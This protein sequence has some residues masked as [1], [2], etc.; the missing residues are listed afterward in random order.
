M[1][2]AQPRRDQRQDPA[3]DQLL[4]LPAQQRG[5]RAADRDD[6]VGIVA[7]HHPP[8]GVAHQSVVPRGLVVL[9]RVHDGLEA[10]LRGARPGNGLPFGELRQHLLARPLPDGD[11]LGQPGVYEQL[12]PGRQLL[13]HVEGLLQRLIGRP[14]VRRHLDLERQRL[15]HGGRLRGAPLRQ[16]GSGL[17]RRLHRSHHGP[18]HQA[19]GPVGLCEVHV[20]VGML[21]QVEHELSQDRVV[22][23]TC[24]QP[25]GHRHRRESDRHGRRGAELDAVP[26]TVHVPVRQQVLGRRL[27]PAGQAEPDD[28]APMSQAVDPAGVGERRHEIHPTTG[29]GLL[30]VTPGTGQRGVAVVDLHPQPLLE[31]LDEHLDVGVRVQRGVGDHLAE[32]QCSGVRPDHP[33]RRTQCALQQSPGAAG[34]GQLRME[35][36]CA[37]SQHAL[38]APTAHDRPAQVST[39]RQRYWEDVP[40]ASPTAPPPSQPPLGL[41]IHQQ[42]SSLGPG[43]TSSAAD[44]SA[45]AASFHLPP[46]GVP[47][48]YAACCPAPRR[49][50]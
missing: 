3:A 10:H 12:A 20:D 47:C 46:R 2:L 18:A 24:G 30:A 1:R 38:A 23:L 32:G 44:R 4:H 43:R 8:L 19:A 34:A 14:D 16:V 5:Q 33:V 39:E 17:L 37:P 31:H 11:D 13:G 27:C 48:L 50:S 25:Q 22:V 41:L 35:G 7:G 6:A 21:S 28:L 49:T 26:V 9:H 29:G 15:R 42:Q 45:R 40:L 36:G